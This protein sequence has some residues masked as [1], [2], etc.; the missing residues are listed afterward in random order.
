MLNALLDIVEI[1]ENVPQYILYAIETLINLIFAAFTV[2]IEVANASLGGLP[3]VITP[4][5]YVS[6]INWYY[7]V[8]TLLA[9]VAP[10]LTA[11]IVWLGISWLY[12][13]YGAI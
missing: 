4:P 13:K 11:Y 8:G 2:A 12:R 1:I 9:V 10:L 7:P 3:E 6:E 5:K